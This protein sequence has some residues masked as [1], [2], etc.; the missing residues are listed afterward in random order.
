MRIAIVLSSTATEGGSFTYEQAVLKAVLRHSITRQFVVYA[1]RVLHQQVKVVD[2]TIELRTTRHGFREKIGAFLRS[3]AA[4]LNLLT[5]FRLRN[6]RFERDLN[7]DG[8]GLVYFLSPNISALTVRSIPI[9]TTVWDLG[10]LDLPYYPEIAG[11]KYFAEREYYFQDTFRRSTLIVTDSDVLAQQISTFYGTPSKRII[12]IP[13]TEII[14]EIDLSI[15][16]HMPSNASTDR[17][18]LYPAQFWPHKRHVLL[19]RAFAQVLDQ[20][21]N[22]RLV[23][24]GGNKGN[25]THVESEIKQLGITDSVEIL[26]FLP[27]EDLIQMIAQSCLVVYPSEL[28]PTNLPPLEAERL[29]TPTVVSASSSVGLPESKIRTVVE[30]QSPDSW[31]TAIRSGLQNASAVS[32]PIEGMNSIQATS[33]SPSDE[34]QKERYSGIQNLFVHIDHLKT[35]FDEWDRRMF[36]R[37]DSRAHLESKG[38]KWMVK[39]LST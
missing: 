19:V 33:F 1:P 17:V 15:D 39:R 28:G 6:S 13:F 5:I 29:G 37:D 10:H 18:I 16:W 32:A 4:G 3:S 24:V 38:D 14:D 30:H 26:D 8:I 11:G 2:P 22:V 31:A 35:H 36:R 20:E 27:R 9:I 34:H 21:Q 23:L 12:L 25:R 7:R